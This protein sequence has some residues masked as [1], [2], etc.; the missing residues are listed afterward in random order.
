L[1]LVSSPALAES[2]R[3]GVVVSTA[4]NL[5][6]AAV[7]ALA[8]S[9]GA[10]LA[11][12]LGVDVIAGVES[13]RRL[14]PSGLPEGC[15]ADIE[16]R[17]DLGARLDADELLMLV[18]VQLGDRVQIDPTWSHLASGRVASRP[19]VTIAEGDDSRTT[20]TAA[21]PSILPHI[22]SRPRPQA[23]AVVVVRGGPGGDSG[24]RMTPV[25]WAAV[26]VA[27]AA[28]VGGAVFAVSAR[29]KY[30]TL[31]DRGCRD[32]PCPA[33][34]IRT[35]RRHSLAADVLFGASLAAGVTAAILYVRSSADEEPVATI[36]GGPGDVGLSIGG[37]F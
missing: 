11:A 5:D 34:D 32:T 24:R 31:E 22:R 36:G 28:A 30:D 29:S 16:C 14:P 9:L 17:R 19:A 25:A 35:L 4:V 23:P 6:D 27:G 33:S 12:E 37:R 13:R 10:A 15:V 26:G 2:T 18:V 7:D 1:L 8:S 3:V 21:A 20:F